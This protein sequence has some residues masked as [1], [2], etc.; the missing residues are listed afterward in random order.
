[1]V[2]SLS[3]LDKGFV[4]MEKLLSIIRIFAWIL[5]LV[6]VFNLVVMHVWVFL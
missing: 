2:P 3:F 5:L 4:V 6:Y 1:M